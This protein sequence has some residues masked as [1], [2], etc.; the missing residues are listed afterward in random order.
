MV[1]LCWIGSCLY[2]LYQFISVQVQSSVTPVDFTHAIC[3]WL[4]CIFR[5]YSFTS[6]H[7]TT[8]FYD[9]AVSALVEHV[10]ECDTY[11]SVSLRIQSRMNFY[12][13]I[14]AIWFLVEKCFYVR[15]LAFLNDFWNFCL[16]AVLVLSIIWF[17]LSLG[18]ITKK[19]WLHS[20]IKKFFG[21]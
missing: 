8:I 16:S 19:N 2:W 20:C 6:T 17:R 18:S 4:C 3:G 14:F 1:G 12:E 10:Y 13:L 15:L 9:A 21:D 11:C 7:K 5:N